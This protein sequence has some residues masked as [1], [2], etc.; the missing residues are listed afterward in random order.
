M[1]PPRP[2]NVDQEMLHSFLKSFAFCS[3][4][5]PANT[6]GTVSGGQ[7]HSAAHTQ[8]PLLPKTPPPGRPHGI[9]QGPCAPAGPRW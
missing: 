2:V 7:G 6:V 3:G 9:Q 5:E 1:W 4:V 8:A